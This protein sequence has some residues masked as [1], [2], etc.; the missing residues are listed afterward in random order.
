MRVS[1]ELKFPISSCIL[2]L[3]F[4]FDFYSWNYNSKRLNNRID[5]FFSRKKRVI[6]KE[7]LIEE[8]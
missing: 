4:K 2:Y 1:F 8:E 6:S 5:I 7:G 3:T